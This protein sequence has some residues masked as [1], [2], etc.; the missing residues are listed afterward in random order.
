MTFSDQGNSSENIEIN[1]DLIRHSEY[2]I[3]VKNTDDVM[4]VND[5][6]KLIIDPSFTEN[7]IEFRKG[8]NTLLTL[9]A[10]DIEDLEITPDSQTNSTKDTDIKIIFNDDQQDKKSIKFKAK[11]QSRKR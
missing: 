6:H 10:V 2:D 7:T 11:R 4:L 8:K 1:S 3:E 9:P 5:A